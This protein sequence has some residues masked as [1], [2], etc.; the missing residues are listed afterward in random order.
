MSFLPDAKVYIIIPV[1]LILFAFMKLIF[2]FTMKETV[3]VISVFIIAAGLYGI[4]ED[5]RYKA[6]VSYNNEEISFSGKIVDISEYSGDKCNY[7]VKGKINGEKTAEI[8]VYTDLYDCRINDYFNFTGKVKTFEDDYIFNSSDYYKAHGI[9]LTSSELSSL[10]II[11][12]KNFSIRRSL[13][14]YKDYVTNF[15]NRNLPQESSAMLSAMLFGDTSSISSDDKTLLYRT[16]IGHF[17]AVSGQHLALFCGIFLF[18][19]RKIKLGKIQT[20]IFLE[21]MIS[22]FAVCSGLSQSVMRSALMMTLVNLAPVFKRKADT[23][24]SISL[25]FVALTFINPFSIR[26]P[27]LI[28]SIAGVFSTGVFAPFVMGKAKSDTFLMKKL[29][30]FVYMFLVSLCILP[31][32]VIFFGESSFIAPLANI[33]LTPLCLAALFLSLIAA[34]TVF[35]NP[36]IFIKIAGFICEIILSGIRFIG[37]FEFSGMKLNNEMKYVSAAAVIVCIIVFL[38][39]KSRKS[40]VISTA[41]CTGMAVLIASAGMF[42]SRNQLDIAL[43]GDKSIDVIVVSKGDSTAVIDISG[44]KKNYRYSLKFLQESNIDNLSD[45]IIKSNALQAMSAYHNGFSL[46][47]TENVVLPSKTFVR[48]DT[49]ICGC[50]PEFSDYKYFD[51]TLDN[52]QVN[53]SGTRVFIKYGEF[54]FICDSECSDEKAIVYAEYENIFDPPPAKAVIVP[55]YESSCEY[56]NVL[57]SRNV[58]IIA[59]NDGS[60]KIGGL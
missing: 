41:V 30:Y 9:F 47:D 22:A 34:L 43:L 29:R 51:L 38:I 35:L 25:S 44:R 52:V 27:S 45:I 14:E 55:E 46:I 50:E 18:I 39:F 5:Y 16:G 58:H 42:L 11:G 56:E 57:T 12:N 21:V 17:M 36:V 60:F 15:I 20:F 26:D 3:T 53:I 48:E 49:E 19:F 54:E 6:I 37:K 4:H 31:F 24:N 7:H 59:E 8:N 40:V 28:L 1:V 33:I 2:K 10:E 32:S 13:A 23:L